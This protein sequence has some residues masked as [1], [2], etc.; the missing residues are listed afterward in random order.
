MSPLPSSLPPSLSLSPSALWL[1]V[2]VMSVVVVSG[3]YLFELHVADKIAEGR[4]RVGDVEVYS[5]FSHLPLCPSKLI[6]F[7]IWA[8]VRMM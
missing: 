6:S 2:F 3:L 5:L 8:S 1:V 4:V 7:R